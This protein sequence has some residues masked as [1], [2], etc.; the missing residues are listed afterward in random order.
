LLQCVNRL[1]GQNHTDEE[2]ADHDD[3]QRSGA[4]Q[5]GLLQHVL[6]LRQAQSNTRQ[7]PEQEHQALAGLCDRPRDR[8]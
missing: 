7:H 6:D 8:G 3:D 4:D 2:P 5:I 1:Q